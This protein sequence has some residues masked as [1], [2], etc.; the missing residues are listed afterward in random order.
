MYININTLEYKSLN[1]NKFYHISIHYHSIQTVSVEQANYSL[2]C[3]FSFLDKEN[4]SFLSNLGKFELVKLT[5]AG[6]AVIYTIYT[7]IHI[8]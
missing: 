3:N 4:I 8:L 2:P 6:V 7:I 5:A 1:I